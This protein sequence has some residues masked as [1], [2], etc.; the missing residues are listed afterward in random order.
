MSIA[1]GLST[2]SD[3]TTYAAYIEA[4]KGEY[5]SFNSFGNNSVRGNG[6]TNYYGLGVMIHSILVNNFYVEGSLRVG[7]SNTEYK[8]GDFG[9]KIDFDMSRTYYGA[10]FGI[11]NVINLGEKS[12]L[13]IYAKALYMNLD[14]DSV[15]IK[16]DKFSFDD[17]NS[18]RTKIGARYSYDIGAS[19]LY[20]GAAYDREFD[21]KAKGYN[22]ALKKNIE[23]PS[24]KGNSA[25]LELGTSLW[26]TDNLNLDAN[27]QGYFGQ[28]EGISGGVKV[29]YRF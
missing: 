8:S 7:K 4:G 13:D 19:S 17:V 6:D 1:A 11:G 20:F 15:T 26:A 21:G 2:R 12:N 3:D 29:E 14:K 16:G 18:I 9:Q 23:S 22:H 5:D 24:L 28:K 25:V 10:H 27:L